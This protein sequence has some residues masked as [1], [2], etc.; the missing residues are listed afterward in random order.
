MTLAVDQGPQLRTA[1]GGSIISGAL[2][3]IL[4]FGGAIAWAHFTMISGAVIAAGTVEVEGKPKLVQHL[5]G[6]IVN[7]ISVADGQFVEGG[8]VLIRLDDTLLR[9][10]LTIYRTRLSEALATRD[11]LVAEQSGAEAIQFSMAD[12][13]IGNVDPTL[14][15]TGQ[16]EVFEARRQFEAG[17]QEQLREKIRQFGNQSEGVKALIASKERQYALMA[18][19]LESLSVLTEKGLAKASQLLGLQRQ[20]A[21][22]LGQIAEHNSELAR[23]ENSIRDAELQIL[24]GQRQIKEDVVTKLRDVTTQIEELRQQILS[25]SQQLDRVA[26]RSPVAGRV[27]ELQFTTIGGVVPPG[28]TIVQVVPSDGKLNFRTRVEPAS[29]DQVY[30]GQ[31]AKLRFPSFNQR[32]TPEL[33]G[34][35]MEISPTSVED[36]A[37]HQSFFWV[38]IEVSPDE[39]ARLGDL[40]LVP[41]MPVQAFL[42]TN[43]RSVLNYLTKPFADQL[44]VA[45]REE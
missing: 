28:A 6:G 39:L 38:N 13:L 9:A 36:P 41:G 40:E 29:V 37:T 4:L 35:V 18:E 27:H 2:G 34:S 30:Y 20:E 3:A 7:E 19:E 45:F 21:D 44:H 32:T 11:R 10:N 22:L 24:Q 17:R 43:D 14:H 31:P 15:Q 1:L 16:T 23:I 42:T 26:V 5:D 33:T 8:D 12:P 25:T